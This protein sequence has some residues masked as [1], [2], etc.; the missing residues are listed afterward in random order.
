MGTPRKSRAK[1]GSSSGPA[2]QIEHFVYGSAQQLKEFRAK[3]PKGVTVRRTQGGLVLT[4]R[5]MAD[6]EPDAKVSRMTARAVTH[7]IEYDGWGQVIVEPDAE[8]RLDIQSQSFVSRTGIHPGLGFS[9]PLSTGQFG[10]AVFLGESREGFLL[11]DIIAG[12]SDRPLASAGL[13]DAPRR[14][15]QPIIVWHTGFVALPLEGDA[16]PAA[17]LPREVAFRMGIGWASPEDIARLEQQF[18]IADPDPE[19]AW[20]QLLLHLAR[21]RRRLPGIESYSV[22]TAT[23]SRGGKLKIMADYTPIVFRERSHPPMPW[24]PSTIDE[25]MTALAGGPDL[26]AARDIVT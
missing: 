6:E 19:S 7:G 8:D 21:L 10:H 23:C 24:Q 18:K 3:L 22:W 12:L 17:K 16:V 5:L 4:E 25:V 13:A 9:L 1:S 20:T 15:R 11:L 26:I 14:Y 2:D